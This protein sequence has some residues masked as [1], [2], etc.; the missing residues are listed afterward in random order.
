[1]RNLCDAKDDCCVHF[2]I[3][4][5][6]PVINCKRKEKMEESLKACNLTKIKKSICVFFL[7]IASMP[8]IMHLDVW[9]RVNAEN[10]SIRLV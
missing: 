10:V 9:T 7:H 3:P 4:G 2:A 8:R 5:Q 6:K 1:M